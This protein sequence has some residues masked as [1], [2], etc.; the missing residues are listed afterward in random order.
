MAR[1]LTSLLKKDSEWRRDKNEIEAFERLKRALTERP[2]L[3]IY[4]SSA[5]TQL[6]TDASK[7]VEGTTI[8]LEEIRADA[9]DRIQGQQGKDRE[10]LFR[11]IRAVTGIE[12]QSKKLEAK[13][14]GPYRIKKTGQGHRPASEL[15]SDV[16]D[17]W[18]PP[19]HL[20]ILIH[21]LALVS[22]FKVTEHFHA[23]SG[24]R[25]A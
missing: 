17:L 5:E 11:V 9:R 13:C 24:H 2:V 12:E 23:D 14:Q 16:R 15:T 18:L 19:S 6:H 20:V 1:P 25:S 3:A 4:N 21:G 7:F 10:D 8:D 22:L